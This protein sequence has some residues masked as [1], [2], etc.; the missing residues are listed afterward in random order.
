MAEWLRKIE[1]PCCLVA[2]HPTFKTFTRQQT[3]KEIFAYFERLKRMPPSLF[4]AKRTTTVTFRT[5][6]ANRRWTGAG[7]AGVAQGVRMLFAALKR[8]DRGE[9]RASEAGFAV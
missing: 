3:F 9:R 8:G 6:K 2:R 1:K 5:S 7:F 4:E